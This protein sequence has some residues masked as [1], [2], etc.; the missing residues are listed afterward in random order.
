MPELPDGSDFMAADRVWI[1][2]RMDEGYYTL[3]IDPFRG[4]PHYPLISSPYYAIEL[5][6][7][8]NRRYWDRYL[9]VWDVLY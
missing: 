7:I 8:A 4:K 2:A 9:P 1:N 6:E 3:D 5:V